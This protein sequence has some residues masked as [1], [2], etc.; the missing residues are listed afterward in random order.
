MLPVGT[1]EDGNDVFKNI[2]EYDCPST[3]LGLRIQDN[4]ISMP[5]FESN[6][7]RR[8]NDWKGERGD[9]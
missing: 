2:V 1:D 6:I 8:Y 9:R 4:E 5:Y 3:P 7:L